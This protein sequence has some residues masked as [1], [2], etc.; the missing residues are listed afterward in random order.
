MS[1]YIIVNQLSQVRDALQVLETQK[2]LLKD[3]IQTVEVAVLDT[4]RK[5]DLRRHYDAELERWMQSLRSDVRAIENSLEGFRQGKIAVNAPMIAVWIYDGFLYLDVDTHGHLKATVQE[6]VAK[7]ESERVHYLSMMH[8]LSDAAS[9]YSISA[10]P[11]RKVHT[12]REIMV[13]TD[14]E[15]ILLDDFERYWPPSNG[16]VGS[17]G[18]RSLLKGTKASFAFL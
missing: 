11:S 6:T 9:N 2:A 4:R 17:G 10:S 14:N 7:L 15:A 16:A 18:A 12:T 5:L 13:Q 8:T 1:T 3:Q